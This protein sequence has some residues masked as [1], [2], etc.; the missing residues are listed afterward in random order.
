MAAGGR[1]RWPRMAQPGFRRIFAA[2]GG[3]CLMTTVVMMLA[4]S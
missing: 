3:V 4:H 2:F 1:R